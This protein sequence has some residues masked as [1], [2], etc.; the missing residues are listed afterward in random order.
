[1]NEV[2]LIDKKPNIMKKKTGLRMSQLSSKTI[3]TM[4]GKLLFIRIGLIPPTPAD[5]ESL[6]ELTV[7]KMTPPLEKALG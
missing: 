1:M 3:M 7:K 5:N 6:K 2:A 4:T